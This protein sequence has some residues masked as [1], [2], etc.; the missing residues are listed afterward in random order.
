MRG[1]VSSRLLIVTVSTPSAS[2]ALTEP[3][4]TVGGSVKLRGEEL[5]RV[6]ERLRATKVSRASAVEAEA[7]ASLPVTYVTAWR[8]LFH[9]G[10]LRPGDRIVVE[11]AVAAQRA[12][13]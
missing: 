3:S 1:L 6:L 5:E 11:G 8:T 13:Y 10:G 12:T 2:F 7:A 4:S 9:L